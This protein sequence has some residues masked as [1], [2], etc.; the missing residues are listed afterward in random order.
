MDAQIALTHTAHASHAHSL[1]PSFFA[2]SGTAGRQYT[3]TRSRSS[4]ARTLAGG[5]EEARA[6]GSVE[7]DAAQRLLGSLHAPHVGHAFA[8]AAW[9]PW[10]PSWG[11]GRRSTAV[12][13][14]HNC[15]SRPKCGRARATAAT[16]NLLV[17][18]NAEEDEVAHVHGQTHLEVGAVD[19]A[20]VAA[21]LVEPARC[22]PSAR[23]MAPMP[24][25]VMERMVT[26]VPTTICTIWHVVMNMA[27]GLRHVRR[28]STAGRSG[29]GAER[30]WRGCGECRPKAS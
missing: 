11:R 25:Q 12:A 7:V 16:A 1:L 24:H 4:C 5:V 29:V 18:E 23:T 13:R 30:T 28:H 2:S 21:D 3:S 10:R 17:E 22:T 15:V 14:P 9:L 26:T 20:L 8:S 19:V 6:A 27:N